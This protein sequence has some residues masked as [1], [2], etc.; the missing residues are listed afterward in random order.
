[1][2]WCC[3]RRAWRRARRWRQ[4][5]LWGRKDI[6][7]SQTQH[8][9]GYRCRRLGKSG[10]QRH[11][12]GGAFGTD[13]LLQGTIYPAGMDGLKSLGRTDDDGLARL[14]R[15]HGRKGQQRAD[16][17]G[18]HRRQKSQR[19]RKRPVIGATSVHGTS[20]G[21]RNTKRNGAKN[22]TSTGLLWCAS[23]PQNGTETSP[24]CVD[25]LYPWVL[26]SQPLCV[27]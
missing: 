12:T 14:C 7:I 1:M 19:T 23:V 3:G 13:F 2:R 15:S 5:Q 10:H 4:G 9:R 6:A 22:H 27:P 16:T 8:G 24:P 26:W 18:Q 25:C 21:K 11:N 20:L 17:D